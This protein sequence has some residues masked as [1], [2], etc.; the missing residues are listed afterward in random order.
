MHDLQITTL[1]S[2]LVGIQLCT[3]SHNYY[4]L[5]KF[6]GSTSVLGDTL[7]Y[8]HTRVDL[9]LGHCMYGVGWQARPE[10]CS[11]DESL[12]ITVSLTLCCYIHHCDT[13][14]LRLSHWSR[15][16]SSELHYT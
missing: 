5:C 4:N 11:V 12:N 3:L 13:N 7:I 16:G 1:K 8:M 10:L 6:K 14:A 9:C 2:A 15:S